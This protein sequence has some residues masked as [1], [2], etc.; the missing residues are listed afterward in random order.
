MARFKFLPKRKQ[1]FHHKTN[2]D[3]SQLKTPTLQK[4]TLP[5]YSSVITNINA[6][7]MGNNTSPTEQLQTKKFLFTQSQ[8][9]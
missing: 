4:P 8:L 1:S 7:P 9:Q 5:N 6:S 3:T 2:Y